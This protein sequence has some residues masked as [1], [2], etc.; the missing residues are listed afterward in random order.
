MRGTVQRLYTNTV[1]GVVQPGHEVIEIIP[2]DDD[3]LIEA[4]VSP[5]DIAFL[6]PGQKAI[7]KFTAY[8]FGIYGGL[9]GV[10]TYI[11]ADTILD[12]DKKAA[13]VSNLMVVLCSDKAANPVINTGTLNN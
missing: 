12:D 9:E 3:L 2:L 8:D 10:V 13:M 6:H 5:K 11:S 1:G 7:V 4:K